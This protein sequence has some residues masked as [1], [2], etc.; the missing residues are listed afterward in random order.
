MAVAQMALPIDRRNG[1]PVPQLTWRSSKACGGAK[2]RVSG[3]VISTSM[4][5]LWPFARR[6]SVA[7]VVPSASVSRS[8]RRGAARLLRRPGS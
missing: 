8:P 5:G 1:G 3:S 4:P 7:V 2:W 6:W